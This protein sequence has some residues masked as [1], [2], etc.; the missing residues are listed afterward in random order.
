M[1]ALL[2]KIMTIAN[3]SINPRIALSLATIGAAGALLV[4]A[5][6]AVFTDSAESISNNFEV[7]TIHLLLTDDN[8]VAEDT[9][10]TTFNRTDMGP[11]VNPVT[12]TINVQNAGTVP[13]ASLFLKADNVVT[14]NPD[15]ESGLAMDKL[16]EITA[17]TLD[18]FSIL[19]LI[20]DSNGNGI[21]DLDDLESGGA[22]TNI[23]PLTDLNINHPLV[24]TVRLHSTAD[25]TYQGDKVVTTF[26]LTLSQ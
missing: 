13:G 3:F 5:T 14:D 20:P 7:G 16:M 10:D 8:E 4:G 18:G 22:G 6:F 2:Q 25:N 1:L 12:A 24:M 26:T 15:A 21:K 19:T 11:G 23:G 17:A 9:I